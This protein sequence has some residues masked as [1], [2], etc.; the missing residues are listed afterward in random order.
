MTTW[1]ERDLAIHAMFMERLQR[2]MADAG[3]SQSELAARMGGGVTQGNV[4]RWLSSTGTKMTPGRFGT[5]VRALGADP[6]KEFAAVVAAAR[7]AGLM[8]PG[9]AVA[10]KKARPGAGGTV[11]RV[12]VPESMS[13]TDETMPIAARE[14]DDDAEAEAQQDEA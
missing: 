10:R 1:E 8:N 11:I 14:V 9:E 7:D 12:R 2:L 5:A 13:D 3:V 4:S 6:A